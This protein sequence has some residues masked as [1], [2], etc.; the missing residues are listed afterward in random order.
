M[1]YILVGKTPVAEPDLIKWAEWFES[2]NRT[3][4]RDRIG[5]KTISTVFLGIDHNFDLVEHSD[6]N[7]FDFYNEDG[8]HLFNASDLYKKRESAEKALKGL[9]VKVKKRLEQ[10]ISRLG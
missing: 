3:L 4:A 7:G 9:L 5:G 1:R 2:A 6:W 8:V 10:S